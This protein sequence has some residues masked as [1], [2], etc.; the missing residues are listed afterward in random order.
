MLQIPTD[1]SSLADIAL[2]EILRDPQ[3]IVD[4]HQNKQI[5]LVCRKGNDSYVA[6]EA[7]RKCNSSCN[8][9]DVTGGIDAWRKE[10]DSSFPDY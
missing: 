7:L 8:V 6:A 10:I 4:A 2:R 3:T 9:R 1:H 5:I